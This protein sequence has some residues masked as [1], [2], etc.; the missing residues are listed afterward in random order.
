M[1]RPSS[2]KS[3]TS[4]SGLAFLLRGTPV[5]GSLNMLDL[6]NKTRPESYMALLPLSLSVCHALFKSWD[7]DAASSSLP[8]ANTAMSGW[9]AFMRSL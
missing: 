4:R 5:N 1:H 2:T 9:H 6:P 8:F 7:T 3:V